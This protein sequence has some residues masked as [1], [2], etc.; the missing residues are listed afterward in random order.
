MNVKFGEMAHL[1]LVTFKFGDLNG[2]RHRHAYVKFLNS[3]TFAKV[4]HYTVHVHNI[5]E[6]FTRVIFAKFATCSCWQNLFVNL[7]ISISQV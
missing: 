7:S 6:S 2:Q 4:F 5:V 1:V 3:A